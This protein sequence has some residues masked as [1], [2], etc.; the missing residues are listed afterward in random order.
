MRTK[1]FT[2]VALVVCL[3]SVLTNNSLAFYN[4]QTGHWLTRD[5]SEESGG[6]NLAGFVANDPLDYADPSG[7][8]KMHLEFDAFIPNNIGAVRPVADSPLQ[9]EGWF[10]DPT[11]LSL[12]MVG[13]DA[14]SDFQAPFHGLDTEKTEYRLLTYA[15]INTDDLS[16]NDTFKPKAGESHR[17]QVVSRFNGRG[18]PGTLTFVPH[19]KEDL[20]TK[21]TF[22]Q[23]IVSVSKT[24][25]TTTYSAAASYPFPFLGLHVAPP[26]T[27]NV[28]WTICVSETGKITV[29][30][31]GSHNAFPAYEAAVDGKVIYGK[32]PDA[33]DS[34]NGPGPDNL[35]HPH[36]GVSGR[37]INFDSQPQT[38]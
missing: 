34:N 7:L 23:S 1:Q 21:P 10:H 36:F 2:I 22:S 38:F 6:N 3:F 11:P 5:P 18:H 8:R 4:S 30:T 14:R 37:T 13:T 15:D 31:F 35:G 27:F 25:L 19:S 28:T 24:S 16:E 33:G 12:Y 26:I 20:T 9:N 32:K 17:I 29:H